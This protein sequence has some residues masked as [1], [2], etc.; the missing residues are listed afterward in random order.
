MIWNPEIIKAERGA[1][2]IVQHLV[3]EIES[4]CGGALSLSPPETEELARTVEM[5][6]AESDAV[7]CVDAGYL[8]LLASR[9][10]SSVGQEHA[11]SRLYLFGTGMIK[12]AEWEVTGEHQLWVLDLKRMTV[13]DEA[14]LEMLFFRSLTMIIDSIADVWDDAAGCGGLGLRNVCR[15]VE[16]LAGVDAGSRRSR[17]LTREIIDICRRKLHKLHVERNWIAVPDVINLD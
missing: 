16:G 12:P 2:G 11:G 7:E 14:P 9:A 15:S 8:V 10:L 4:L 3:A 17:L 13:G 1:S 6:L 5:F